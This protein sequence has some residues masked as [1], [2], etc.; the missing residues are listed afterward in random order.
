MG[1]EEA[2]SIYL[3]R[4]NEEQPGSEVQHASADHSELING[5]WFLRNADGLLAKVG[6]LKNQVFARILVD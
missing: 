4:A 3:N 1:Y 6:T 2:V 5:V